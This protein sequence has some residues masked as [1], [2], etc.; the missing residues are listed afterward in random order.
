M[1]KALDVLECG[2]SVARIEWQTRAVVL[3]SGFAFYRNQFLW[4]EESDGL[5]KIIKNIK[6]WLLLCS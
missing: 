6:V 5:S 1:L 4:K 2:Y 3:S